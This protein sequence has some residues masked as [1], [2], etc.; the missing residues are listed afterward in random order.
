[1]PFMLHLLLN[2]QDNQTE[3]KQGFSPLLFRSCCC[4]RHHSR[5]ARA[6]VKRAVV[7]VLLARGCASQDFQAYKPWK[8]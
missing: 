3:P 2:Q 1:M 7:V 5:W 8:L 6:A 4:A